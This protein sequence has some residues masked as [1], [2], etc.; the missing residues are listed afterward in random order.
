MRKIPDVPPGSE[1]WANGWETGYEQCLLDQ[2]RAAEID[3]A[4]SPRTWAI[5]YPPAPPA[6]T[7]MLNGANVPFLVRED[8][9]LESDGTDY[10]WREALKRFGPFTEVV[11]TEVEAAARRLRESGFTDFS[12]SIPASLKATTPD[13]AHDIRVVLAHVLNGGQ[14]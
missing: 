8:G 3:Q 14:L 10:S 11:E 7:R 4:E 13:Y 1:Q 6:G 5:E 2:E 12:G 9:R